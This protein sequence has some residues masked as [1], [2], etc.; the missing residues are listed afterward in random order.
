VAVVAAAAGLTIAMGGSSVRL[1]AA[2]IGAIDTASGEV[3]AALHVASAPSG[4]AIGRDGSIWVTSTIAGTLSRIDPTTHTVTT[5]TVGSEPTAVVAAPDGLSVWVANSGSGTVARVSPQSDSVVAT[6]N[7]GAGP[8]AL[9]ATANSVWVAN[10]LSASVSEIAIQSGRVVR[11][12]GVG[13]EPAGIAAGGGSIWVTDQGNGTVYRLDQ[14]T[15]ALLAAPIDVGSGPVGIAFGS[16]AAWIVNSIDGTLSRIDAQTGAVT[17]N[18][19]GQGPVDVAVESGRVWVADEYGDSVAEVDPAT[20]AVTHTTL[21]NGAPLSLATAGSR[22]WV[23]TDGTGAAAHRGR[24]LSGIANVVSDFPQDIPSI[25]P[26]SAY[27]PGLWR[28]LVMTSDGLVG[29]RKT[30]GVAGSALVPDLAVSLPVPTDHGLVYRFQIRRG[31]RYSNGMP[32]R[33]S[34]FRRGLE[35]SFEVIGGPLQYFASLI[36]GQRCFSANAAAAKAGRPPPTCNLSRAIV[37]DDATNTVTFHL[38]SRDPEL[39]NQLTLPVAYPVAPGTPTQLPTGGAV[40]GTG[41]YEITHYVPV[42]PDGSPRHGRLVLKRNPYFRQWS[43]AAQPSGFPDQIVVRTNYSAQDEVTAVE[44]GRADFAWDTPP[45]NSL[46]VLAQTYP[47]ELHRTTQSQTTFLWLNVRE[48]PFNSVL[49]RRALN[50]AIDRRALVTM[51]PGSLPGRVTCQLLPPNFPGYVPYC[52]YTVSPS[53]SGRWVGPDLTKAQTLVRESGTY[54]A[55]V[56]LLTYTGSGQTLGFDPALARTVIA[57]LQKLGYRAQL[58]VV[59]FTTYYGPNNAQLY[60]R[61]QLG[62][63]AW[64]A[65][66]VAP[67]S[68][69]ISLVECGQGWTNSG[70]FCDPALDARI[71]KALADQ[72]DQA[73]VASGEWAAIDRSLADAAVDVPLSNSLTEDFVS[74][75][76]GNYT[77]NPQWG[78]LLDQLWVH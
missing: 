8:T 66:Y 17:T 44:R 57:T 63:N 19:V 47:A 1:G 54:G 75:R 71:G 51:S 27:T 39:L 58:K 55:K 24:V 50:Y 45:S 68:F 21:T 36:G 46:A 14:T 38:S 4:V 15:G 33:A 34:D 74:G 43:A 73:G 72:A 40:P 76:V 13:P 5:I 56:T 18:H 49:A 23:A 31:V 25:D 3:T 6:V 29:Y 30:G 53:A 12:V 41:P 7:V 9:A 28:I 20:L 10:T 69:L 64:L 78:M 52:R 48:A 65:D 59:P 35:R 67:S 2:E 11:T 61:A 16:G 37:A 70:Q 42:M 60:D 77:Y 26:G 32:V 62:T 22:L